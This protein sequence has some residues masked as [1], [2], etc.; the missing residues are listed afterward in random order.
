LQGR[1]LDPPLRPKT[2]SDLFARQTIYAVRTA[3]KLNH[4]PQAQN[5]DT[6][7]ANS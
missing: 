5:R 2:F 3:S 6:L 1:V 7:M 4:N